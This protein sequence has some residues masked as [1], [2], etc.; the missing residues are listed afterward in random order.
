MYVREGD[1]AN[2]TNDASAAKSRFEG[3]RTQLRPLAVVS[4][5]SYPPILLLQDFVFCISCSATSLLLF[6]FFF[7]P[8]AALAPPVP[9]PSQRATPTRN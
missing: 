9:C 1:A 2:D 8:G 3:S 4:S 5:T 7:C 6:F